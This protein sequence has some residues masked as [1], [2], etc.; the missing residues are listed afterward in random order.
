MVV[1]HCYFSLPQGIHLEHVDIKPISLG[2][3]E[4]CGD[5]LKWT[6]WITSKNIAIMKGVVRTNQ[7]FNPNYVVQ[8]YNYSYEGLN[9][10]SIM[11]IQV[12]I[13]LFMF[14]SYNS[15]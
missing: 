6:A 8:T 5:E 12:Y 14:F 13:L 10:S 11:N 9:P 7:L 3:A 2:F 15:A 4:L 1:F